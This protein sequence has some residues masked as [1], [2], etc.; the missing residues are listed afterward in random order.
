MSHSSLPLRLIAL[1]GL[2]HA[3]FSGARLTLTL[4]AVHLQASPLVVGVLMSLLMVLPVF[5]AVPVGRW[6]DRRGHEDA[7]LLG[8]CLTIAGC[9]MA[10][11]QPSLPMLGL[12]GMLAG[13]GFTLTHV[14]VNNAI[15][16]A[17]TSENRAQAF[18]AMAVAFSISGLVAPLSAG[19]MIDHGSH[20][21]A[22]LAMAVLALTALTLLRRGPK[23][24]EPPVVSRDTRSGLAGML[25]HPP[26]RAA[27]V[28]GALMTMGWDLFSFLLPLHGARS[29]LSATAI[30]IVVGAF[31][32]GSFSVRVAIPRLM[33]SFDEW[34]LMALAMGATA[35]CYLVFPFLTSVAGLLPLAYVLGM[36]L[37]CG[38]PLS[39][40]LVHMTAPP[41]RS[42]E[43]V[44]MRSSVVSASQATLPLVVGAVGAFAGLFPVFWIAAGVLAWGSFY[45][46]GRR[47]RL[48]S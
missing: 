13:S 19:L 44:G 21:M 36:L 27:L 24:V 5:I 34:R 37:G 42:G 9:V 8:V 15:G 38:Q 6:A 3:G 12:A 7:T 41:G 23:R 2:T 11:L 35:V 28:V 10:A 43:A 48:S 26:L 32:A 20:R 40:S 33:R 14:G 31:G 4:Q 30:G 17:T 1:L 18:G 29:G 47:A 16:H 25:R 45:T 22:F 46:E 39:M